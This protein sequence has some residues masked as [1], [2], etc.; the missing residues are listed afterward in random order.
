MGQVRNALRAYAF[1]TTPRVSVLARLNRLITGLGDSGLA[2]ALF[3][4]LDVERRARSAGPCA[5]HPPPLLIGAA[6]GPAPVASR[7]A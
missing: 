1:A 4:R 7:R 2:T 5:G 6:G 3:G